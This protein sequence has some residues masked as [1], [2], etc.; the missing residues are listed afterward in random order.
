MNILI[1]KK[2]KLDKCDSNYVIKIEENRKIK[3]K[4]FITFASLF[5]S[6]TCIF[7]V[8][9]AALHHLGF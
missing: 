4:A 6:G 8:V 9:I 7:G 2:R 5:L 3:L 1:V